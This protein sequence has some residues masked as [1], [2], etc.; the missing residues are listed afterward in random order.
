[1]S[2]GQNTHQVLAA[3]TPG[4]E[5]SGEATPAHSGAAADHAAPVFPN[6][7]DNGADYPPYFWPVNSHPS[8]SV[9]RA[10][11]QLRMIARQLIELPHDDLTSAGAKHNHD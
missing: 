9:W 10:G 11:I 3:V 6:F 1:M 5:D 4:S 2:G 7:P 8:F